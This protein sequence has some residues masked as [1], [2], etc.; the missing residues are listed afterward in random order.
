MSPEDVLNEVEQ[1]DQDTAEFDAAFDASAK[2]IDAGKAEESEEAPGAGGAEDEAGEAGDFEESFRD[3]AAG[4]AASKGDAKD[5][6]LAAKLAA[7]EAETE[8][9][10][11]SERSQRGRVSALT[12]KLVEQQAALK[13]P[14]KEDK[15]EGEAG[16]SEGEGDDWEEFAREFPEMAAVVEKRLARVDRKVESVQDRVERVATTAD[17]LAEKELIAYKETQFEILAEKHPD[18]DEIKASP[19]WERFKAGADEETLSKIKS[20]HAEDAIEVLDTFKASTGWG[21]PPVK[22]GRT[23]SEIELINERRAAALKQSTGITSKKVGHSTRQDT[24]TDDDFDAAFAERAS[25]KER[26]RALLR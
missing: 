22:T 17:T 19:E 23:K 8:R 3:A 14:P 16:K 12:K 25:K 21:N 18:F 26:E 9:L 15:A 5:V 20:K 1:Q 4:A 6:D 24:A 7:L 13:E 10:R 2:A 11:Q